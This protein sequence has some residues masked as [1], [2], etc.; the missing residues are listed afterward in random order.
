MISVVVFW[1]NGYHQ[2]TYN[3]ARTTSTLGA[4]QLRAF[5]TD[6]PEVIKQCPIGVEFVE[7]DARAV[8]KEVDG[9]IIV[10]SQ[11]LE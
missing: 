3:S 9:I 7:P 5:Q 10:C 1:K 2:T 8:E 6:A 11:R 4:T